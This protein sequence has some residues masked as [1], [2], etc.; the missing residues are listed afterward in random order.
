MAAST[1]LAVF[2]M[3]S[4]SA[5]WTPRWRA[6]RGADGRARGLAL[7]AEHR[8]HQIGGAVHHFRAVG[9]ARRRIDEAA[10]PHH[11][12]D[13]VEIAERGL[14]LGDQA[15]GAGPRRLL[16]V[17][18][19]D[20][21]AEL[22]R[23]D[24]L[25]V[26]TK[27]KLAGDREQVAGAHEGHVIGDRLGRLLERDAERVELAFDGTGHGVLQMIGFGE[28]IQAAFLADPG[29]ACKR[30]WTRITV[31]AGGGGASLLR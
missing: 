5:S 4:S 2:S 15:D 25:A 22:P 1:A 28:Q 8:N 9:E 11:L 17:L 26:A 7:V 16:A 6:R 14:D 30:A 13:L 12:L 29:R 18:D 21:G 27:A 24:E 23:G 31:A 10:E 20:A 3:I 19:G